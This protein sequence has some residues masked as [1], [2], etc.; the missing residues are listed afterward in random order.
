MR[1]DLLNIKENVKIPKFTKQKYI[2]K[3]VNK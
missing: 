1:V 3:I 2:N